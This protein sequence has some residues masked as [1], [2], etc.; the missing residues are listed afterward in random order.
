MLEGIVQLGGCSVS[1][2]GQ[3]AWSVEASGSERRRGEFLVDGYVYSVDRCS[4]QRKQA[5][6]RR[7]LSLQRGV[8][9]LWSPAGRT[10]KTHH[11]PGHN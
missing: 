10:R 1:A 7:V 11:V 9:A 4:R 3:A 2:M 6:D 8:S 5:F